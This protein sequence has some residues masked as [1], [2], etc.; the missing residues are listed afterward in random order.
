[1]ISLDSLPRI[2]AALGCAD[3]AR[4]EDAALAACDSGEDFLEF[5]LDLLDRAESGIP[6]IRRV[7]RR[8]PET[9]ILATCRRSEAGGE[10]R[11]SR[12]E[13]LRLLAEAIKAGAQIVDVEI[14]TA[15]PCRAEMPALR[16]RARLVVSYHNFDKT[17]ALEGV[18]KRLRRVPADIYKLATMGHKPSDS[19]RAMDLARRHPGLRVVALVMGETGLPTRILGPARGC[20]FVFGSPSPLPPAADRNGAAATTPPTA[21][22]QIPSAT[23]RLRYQVPKLRSDAKIYG[24]VADPVGHSMSPTLHN[25]AFQARRVNAVYLPFRVNPLHLADFINVAEQLPLEGVSVT[26]PHKQ[27][28]MRHLHSI[29]PLAKRI[30]AVNTIFRKK[31]KLCGTNTDAAG[32]TVPLEK[33]LQLNKASVLIAGNGGAARGAIFALGDAGAAVTL[34]G[35]SPQ[36]VRKLARECDVKAI[37]FQAAQR[38]HFDVLINATPVGMYPESEACLFGDAIPADLVFDMVYNPLETVLLRRAREARKQTISGLEMFI[39]QAA[40]QFEIWTGQN[41]PRVAMRNAVLE[42][43]GA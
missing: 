9:V 27:R 4:L 32:I 16:E 33:K 24:V 41:A 28:I 37:D 23:L 15:A 29:D 1:M 19:L 31:R 8:Y 12:E 38:G 42:A 30:G 36:K 10:Y 20:L 14:E 7:L 25:R 2:C 39:E 11:G 21:P 34:T 43:L 22:G 26:I 3:R 18:V 40:A 13:Q 35:R 17:P 6:V 5:R